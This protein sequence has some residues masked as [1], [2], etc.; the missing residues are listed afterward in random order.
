MY[1]QSKYG[2]SSCDKVDPVPNICMK[3][4]RSN[5]YSNEAPGLVSFLSKKLVVHFFS[6]ESVIRAVR[7]RMLELSR[8]FGRDSVQAVVV[9]QFVHVRLS[10]RTLQRTVRFR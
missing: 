4:V 9:L 1:F 2:T 7:W 10:F 6:S 8:G 5:A 3:A